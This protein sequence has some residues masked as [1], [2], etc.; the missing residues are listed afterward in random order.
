MKDQ[1]LVWVQVSQREAQLVIKGNGF[2]PIQTGKYGMG[3][4]NTTRSNLLSEVERLLRGSATCGFGVFDSKGGRIPPVLL[5][6]SVL[7]RTASGQPSILTGILCT[8]SVPR[9]CRIFPFTRRRKSAI[10]RISSARIAIV[11]LS[12]TFET[13]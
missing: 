3:V 10:A 1:V 8:V 5:P 4:C 6:T 13:S 7:V 12:H 2:F 11:R 9:S